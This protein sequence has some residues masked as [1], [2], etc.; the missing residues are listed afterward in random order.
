M[1]IILRFIDSGDFGSY[2]LAWAI[3]T[4]NGSPPLT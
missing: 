2:T 4:I 3:N 1:P